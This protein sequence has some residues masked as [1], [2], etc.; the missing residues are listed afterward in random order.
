MV[1]IGEERPHRRTS[2]AP[3]RVIPTR[4]VPSWTPAHRRYC[5]ITQPILLKP[6]RRHPPKTTDPP[7]A[8]TP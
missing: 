3:P 4:T 1:R 5:Y 2:S 8:P 6:P 7:M